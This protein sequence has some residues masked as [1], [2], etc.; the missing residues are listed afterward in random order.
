MDQRD[1]HAQPIHLDS[2]LLPVQ[3]VIIFLCAQI[4]CP[5]ER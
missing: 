4:Y 1:L 5:V 3:F 2:N